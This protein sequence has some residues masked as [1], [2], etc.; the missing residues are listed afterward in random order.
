MP[1]ARMA[2]A[3]VTST[4]RS[5]RSRSSAAPEE[6]APTA[7]RSPG[8]ASV[9]FLRKR[10]IFIQELLAE[11]GCLWVHLDTRKSHYIKV[12]LDE[13]FGEHNFRNEVV[14]KRTSAHSDAAVLGAVHETMLVY[15]K[16]TTMRWNPQYVPYETGTSSSTTATRTT[17]GGSSCLA[18]SGLPA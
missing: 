9:E 2:F 1:T 3:S 4:R 6:P 18:T 7:T 10:L 17:T 15:S 13:V 5:P 8:A 11:D 14:W 16:S 12:V